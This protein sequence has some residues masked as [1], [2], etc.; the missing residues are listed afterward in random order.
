M[1]TELASLGTFDIV[2]YLGVL[3]HGKEPLTAL[4]RVRQVTNEV[5]VI[6]TQ[7]L[8]VEGLKT[9]PFVDFFAGDEVKVNNDFGT[10]YVPTLSGLHA[11][12][13]PRDSPRCV[14]SPG[15][16]QAPRLTRHDQA[17]LTTARSFMR[18]YRSIRVGMIGWRSRSDERSR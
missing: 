9:R 11:L 5:A 6:E 14:Q 2:L 16:R 3:Y 1:T 4:E 7:A 8:W 10:W 15:R 18:G 12:C 17:R 13:R